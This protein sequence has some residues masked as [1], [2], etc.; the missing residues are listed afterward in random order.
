MTNRLVC[1]QPAVSILASCIRLTQ[2]KAQMLTYSTV[3]VRRQMK[4]LSKTKQDGVSTC[5]S[6]AISKIR[7]IPSVF[8]FFPSARRLWGSSKRKPFG[9]ISYE[10][11]VGCVWCH[12]A[13]INPRALALPAL[14]F[15]AHDLR[16]WI[17]HCPRQPNLVTGWTT[18][19]QYTELH[20]ESCH[21]R[22]PP[23][24]PVSLPSSGGLRWG[25]CWGYLCHTSLMGTWQIHFCLSW[26][27]L[28]ETFWFVWFFPL[29]LKLIVSYCVA[30]EEQM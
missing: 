3:S 25:W 19:K 13:I 21:S 18:W 27:A 2:R 10:G 16:V 4:K 20:K 12:G 15:H 29:I 6:L 28:S 14:S 17:S 5:L 9:Q 22:L 7:S 24:H 23:P 11:G 1:G 26:G 30:E 8:S